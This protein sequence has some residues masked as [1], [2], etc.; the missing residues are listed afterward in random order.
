M[1]LAPTLAVRFYGST[2]I[3]FYFHWVKILHIDVY[4]GLNCAQNNFGT[5]THPCLDPMKL[6][7]FLSSSNILVMSLSAYNM[8]Q[9]WKSHV[10]YELHRNQEFDL[11]SP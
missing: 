5:F 2:I 4:R 7:S 8:S 11:E 3:W 10:L 6:L 9:P 1:N